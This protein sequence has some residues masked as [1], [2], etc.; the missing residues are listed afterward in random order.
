MKVIETHEY[1]FP[2][3]LLPALVNNDPVIDEEDRDQFEAFLGKLERYKIAYNA[4]DY[5][6]DYESDSY[7]SWTNCLNGLG[8]DVVDI[9]ILYI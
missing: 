7:F 2:N 4:T 8:C 5:V 1:R 6:V 9:K 3:H